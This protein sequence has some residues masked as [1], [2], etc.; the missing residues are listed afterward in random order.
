M[1]SNN[2]KERLSN[3]HHNNDF[4][5]PHHLRNSSLDE[6]QKTGRGINPQVPTMA[7]QPTS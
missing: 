7:P 4:T 5:G 6:A 2:L 3:L 1:H